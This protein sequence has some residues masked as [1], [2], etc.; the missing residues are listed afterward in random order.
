MFFALFFFPS[1]DVLKWNIN[2]TPKLWRVGFLFNGNNCDIVHFCCSIIAATYATLSAVANAAVLRCQQ[3]A[4]N[5][6]YCRTNIPHLN[7]V[8]DKYKHRLCHKE[9]FKN[10][11]DYE[12]RMVAKTSLLRTEYDCPEAFHVLSVSIC[13]NKEL[14][15]YSCSKRVTNA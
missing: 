11:M 9:P 4:T 15:F 13:S 7:C 5:V 12:G 6:P 1:L 10:L 14:T 8:S 2:G 3:R